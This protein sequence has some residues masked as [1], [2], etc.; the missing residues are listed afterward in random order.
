M[1]TI[2]GFAGI[3]VN[4]D[5]QPRKLYMGEMYEVLS[6][7][8]HGTHC[9]QTMDCVQGTLL[10]E[11]LRENPRVDKQM[12]FGWFRKIALSLER[13]HR[14]RKRQNYKCL[15]PY[16]I[17]ISEDQSVSLLDMEAPEN[18]FVMK[19]MQK[20]A[21][22]NHFLKPVYD[23]ASDGTYSADLFSYGKTLRF[24]LS[25][26][27][28]IPELTNRE[29]TCLMRVT[30]R[31]IG[32]RKK[33]YQDFQ[34]VMNALPS[35][36]TGKNIGV[37][38]IRIPRLAGCAVAGVAVCAF[39]AAGRQGIASSHENM[40]LGQQAEEVGTQQNEKTL[41]LQEELE[42]DTVRYLAETYEKAGMTE[43]ACA[44]YGRLI[45]IGSGSDEI[46]QAAVKKMN[47]EAGQGNY[48]CAVQTGEY[49]MDKLGQSREISEL[50]LEYESETAEQKQVF[51]EESVSQEK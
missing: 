6:F 25:Y 30:G 9:R 48:I 49:A 51:V 17:V 50:L 46:E 11:Y 1:H 37:K 21:M 29:E 24:I 28:I 41:E 32:E 40:Q 44:A 5:A 45:E 15:N 3:L 43:K 7:I 20:R 47:L 38:R 10:I 12:V 31:C 34:Q 2:S 18:E 8:E 13:Y 23:M 16:S 4:C 19:Q 39:L 26:A 35:V 42:L 33:K 14:C 27:E 22:K 36:K